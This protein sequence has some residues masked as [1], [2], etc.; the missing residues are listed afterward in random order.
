MKPQYTM[1]IEFITPEMASEYLKTAGQNRVLSLSGVRRIVGALNE[2]RWDNN[3]PSL[4]IF[5]ENDQLRD[6]QHRCH[7]SVR[8]GKGFWAIVVRN[9][10]ASSFAVLDTGKRRSAADVLGTEGVSYATVTASA[11]KYALNYIE[12]VGLR[13]AR[14]NDEIR[15]F[16]RKNETIS[17]LAKR[18][19]PVRNKFGP[20]PFAAVMF[21]ASHER[22]LHKKI[23]RFIAGVA[24]AAN[25]AY[26]QGDPRLMLREWAERELGRQKGAVIRP[27]PLMMATS[28]AWNAFAAGRS[29][30][31]VRDLASERIAHR[32]TMPITGYR[33]EEAAPRAVKAA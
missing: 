15:A 24:S 33:A 7:G 25:E 26:S 4:V 28:L 16:Y 17:A 3:A 32:D 8:S 2:G 10:P 13:T 20:S 5:D 21:L 30:D 1:S 23:D 12:G 27:E 11:S 19:H 31:H 9:M 6:G 22:A 29:V 18:A 14:D